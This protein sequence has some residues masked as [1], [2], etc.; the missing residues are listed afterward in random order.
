MA[1]LYLASIICYIVFSL[2]FLHIKEAGWG[3]ALSGMGVFATFLQRHYFR[4][5]NKK[6]SHLQKV[7]DFVFDDEASVSSQN[8]SFIADLEND[9]EE[10]KRQGLQN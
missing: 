8:N 7:K 3:I 6:L 1:W 5:Y 10:F 9:D 4:K 2:T